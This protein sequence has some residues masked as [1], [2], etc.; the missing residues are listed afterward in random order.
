M[1]ELAALLDDVVLRVRMIQ[2]AQAMPQDYLNQIGLRFPL[3]VGDTVPCTAYW[4]IRAAPGSTREELSAKFKK[5]IISAAIAVRPQLRNGPPLTYQHAKNVVSAGT[6][7]RR[8]IA[9]LT[10]PFHWQLVSIERGGLKWPDRSRI[11]AG[12]AGTAGLPLASP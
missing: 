11:P 3:Y 4:E 1:S 2:S 6:I 8:A 10:N 12:P 9:I 5:R 7:G